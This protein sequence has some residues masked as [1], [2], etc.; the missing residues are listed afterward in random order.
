[1][2]T[3]RRDTLILVALLAAT[4]ALSGCAGKKFWPF[5][6]KKSDTSTETAATF[7]STPAVGTNSYETSPAAPPVSDLSSS[8]PPSDVPVTTY[9]DPA[10][11]S[12]TQ[13]EPIREPSVLASELQMVH[14]TYDRSELTPQAVQ[15]LDQNVEWL[16]QHPGIQIQIEGHCD[17]RGTVEYNLAL[18]QRRADSVREYLVGKGIDPN[19]LHA[20]SYGKERPLAFG[21]N[22]ADHAMN[23]RAQF[24]IF[25]D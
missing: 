17:E 4:L 11:G 22:E 23:R 12:L 3:A 21:M 14:F 1:M 6:K 20:I 15:I 7:Q 9:Q 18:G 16:L 2:R 19:T 13:P 25:S 24:L 8:R 10:T 5:S